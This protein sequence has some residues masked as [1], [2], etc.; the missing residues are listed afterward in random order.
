MSLRNPLRLYELRGSLKSTEDLDN[1]DEVFI[2]EPKILD[3]S[4]P[5]G[6]DLNE[7]NPT[8]V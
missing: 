4:L 7:D 6:S 5:F 2:G 1:I 3:Y 8:L